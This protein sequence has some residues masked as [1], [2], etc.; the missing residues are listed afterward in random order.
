MLRAGFDEF[1]VD[2]DVAEAWRACRECEAT[3]EGDDGPMY[4]GRWIPD[5]PDARVIGFH[6]PRLIV[7]RTDLVEIVVNSRKTS[8]SD[9]ESF[10]TLDLG[11][12]YL[13]SE[14]ALTER[15]HSRGVYVRARGASV[16]AGEPVRLYGGARR[17]F[18]A[19]P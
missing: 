10:F 3:L 6:A 13:S 9:V 11:L 7:P 15:E 18:G 2:D 17:R 12:P 19:G 14:T 4:Q 5:R 1:D 8:P 16:E